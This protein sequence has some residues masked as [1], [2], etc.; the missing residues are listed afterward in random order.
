MD[1]TSKQQLL[2]SLQ[3]DLDR[4]VWRFRVNQGNINYLAHYAERL[5][6]R[7]QSALTTEEKAHIQAKLVHVSK[8]II[9]FRE[10][11]EHER[12][13]TERLSARSNALL[14][15]QCIADTQ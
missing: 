4:A 12:H 8:C 1:P 7:I 14:L 10:Y 5:N 11:V 2:T 13:Y 15:S 3:E 6:R 9:K